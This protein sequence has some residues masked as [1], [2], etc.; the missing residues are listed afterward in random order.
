[1]L[2]IWITEHI[3]GENGILYYLVTDRTHEWKETDAL[4]LDIEHMNGGKHDALHLGYRA[5]E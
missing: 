4:H 2:Y 3:N 5:R 1:M